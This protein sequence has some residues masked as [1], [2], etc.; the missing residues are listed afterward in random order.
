MAQNNSPA[1]R[2]ILVPNVIN[3]IEKNKNSTEKQESNKTTK[4]KSGYK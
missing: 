2:V 4:N 1:Q 3:L